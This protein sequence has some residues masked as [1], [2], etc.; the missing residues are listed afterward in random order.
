MAPPFNVPPTLACH[1]RCGILTG[2]EREVVALVAQGFSSYDIAQVRGCAK[3]TV[4]NLLS[5]AYRKL[6]VSGRRELGA[7][8]RGPTP[9]MR[10]P[11]LTSRELEVLEATR[12]GLSNKCIAGTLGVALSTVSTTLTRV[13]RKLSTAAARACGEPASRRR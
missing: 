4:A 13:R 5:N 3:S 6:G 12:A 2:A 11:H 7:L 1:A 10:Y 8:L 9:P